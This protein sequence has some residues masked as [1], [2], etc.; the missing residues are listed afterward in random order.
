MRSLFTACVLV[1]GALVL[2]LAMLL[3][4]RLINC[5]LVTIFITISSDKA[6]NHGV[7]TTDE[8]EEPVFCNLCG[9]F[10]RRPMNKFN[11]LCD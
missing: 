2:T 10:L 1:I 7:D 11:E 3:L 4:L 8:K 5:R 6:I 9:I